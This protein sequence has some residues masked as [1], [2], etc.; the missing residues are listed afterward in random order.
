MIGEPVGTSAAITHRQVGDPG[1]GD[2]R[3]GPGSAGTPA[4]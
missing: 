3:K 2:I 1:P 4:T